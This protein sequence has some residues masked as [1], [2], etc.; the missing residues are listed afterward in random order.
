[1]KRFLA[2]LLAFTLIAAGSCSKS[3]APPIRVGTVY[4]LT[5]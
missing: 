3:P 5:G 2:P 1:M 4:P